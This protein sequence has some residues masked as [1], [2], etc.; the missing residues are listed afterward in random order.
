MTRNYDTAAEPDAAFKAQVQESTATLL[1]AAVFT[2]PWIDL[3]SGGGKV[4]ATARSDQ[5]GTLTIQES[6]D[7]S[8][9]QTIAS[10][11]TAAIG[12]KQIA[13]ASVATDKQYARVVY[14][15]G[16]TNQGS[17]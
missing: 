14:T 15:N 3:G 4:T 17:F 16:S 8:A 6:P 9:T 13:S 12:G 11:A 5:S 2:G 10:A 7:K 1:A